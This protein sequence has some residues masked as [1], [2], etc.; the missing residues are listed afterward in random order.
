MGKVI[1]INTLLTLSEAITDELQK[2]GMHQD[3]KLVA[4]S[5]STHAKEVAL[6]VPH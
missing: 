5:W 4:L 3:I 6:D 2:D 1:E